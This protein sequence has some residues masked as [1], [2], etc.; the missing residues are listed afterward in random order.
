MA[1]GREFFLREGGSGGR[2]ALWHSRIRASGAL[3]GGMVRALWSGSSGGARIR[4][5]G[6]PSRL[7][8]RV[9]GGSNEDVG[10]LTEHLTA[11]LTPDVTD[12][13]TTGLTERGVRG[14]AWEQREGQDARVRVLRRSVSAA[15]KVFVITLW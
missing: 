6:F 12:G 1:L 15:F 4:G 14:S 11:G 9:L 8:G 2:E 7:Y 5:K 10:N 3:T 13:L